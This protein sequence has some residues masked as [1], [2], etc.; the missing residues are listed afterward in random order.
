MSDL[1]ICTKTACK[2]F[3]HHLDLEGN[4][5]IMFSGIFGI[6]KTTFLK[7]Y[8]KDHP[9]YNAYHL[10]PVNYS[11]ARNEDIFELIK[12]DV[13]Y[14]LLKYNGWAKEYNYKKYETL[15]LFIGKTF[16]KRIKP[17]VQMIPKVGKSITNVADTLEELCE[18]YPDF[19][20]KI[21]E[22]EQS[23]TLTFLKSLEDEAG[24]IYEMDFY[25]NMI[26]D[27][28]QS[29]KEGGKENILIIDDLDRIDPDHIFR[30][31]NVFA[32]HLDENPEIKNK[33]GFDKV[34]IVLDIENVRSIF[35]ERF[36]AR[37]DFS[38]Y[39]DKFYTYEVFPFSNETAIQEIINQLILSI[40]LSD[41]S[42]KTF[43]I[44]RQNSTDFI[45]LSN[46]LNAL[47]M[48]GV[49]NLRALLKFHKKKY[50]LRNDKF[51]I[52]KKKYKRTQFHVMLIFDYLVSLFGSGIG[53]L[54]AIR[55][56]A[57]KDEQ[58]QFIFRW[59][60]EDEIRYLVGSCILLINASQTKNFT[61]QNINYHF[62]DK[63]L[64]N[65]D[66]NTHQN[67]TLTYYYGKLNQNFSHKTSMYRVLQQ[68][69]EFIESTIK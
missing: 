24:S 64:L 45:H 14:E 10:F 67:N 60:D 44:N 11:V 3:D 62:K 68:T 59:G 43:T 63:L 7:E 46:I 35:H 51:L 57:E 30:I 9:K 65:Y 5:R 37:T 22:G 29:K 61:N 25:S 21:N 47:V 32:A 27:A 6:G 53:L 16:S 2:E 66:E 56:L 1:K 36:G 4:D 26:F 34:I 28:L 17:F 15:P 42:L 52:N 58:G 8:F 23:K 69:F 41:D 48:S 49:I 12:Y 40:S 20:E 54:N 31:L 55:R 13:F 33:F 19:H 50:H 18:T 39:I 38:G